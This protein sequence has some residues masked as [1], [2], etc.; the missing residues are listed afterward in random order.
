MCRAQRLEPCAF[1]ALI[2]HYA[3]KLYGFLCRIT[4]KPHDAEDLVQ[5]VFLR[6][7]RTIRD[8]QPTGSFDAWVFQ[9]AVNLARDRIR[10]ARRT[11]TTNSLEMLE[12]RGGTL[13]SRPAEPPDPATPAPD[14]PLR[15]AEDVDRLQ[16]AL[17]KLSEPEREVIMLRHYGQM[18]FAEIA[19][20]MGTPLGT[21]LARAHRGL[22]KLRGWMESS[23]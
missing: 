16:H 8:Y 4:G 1:D 23:S 13:G 14:E 5:E 3:H 10:R 19:K 15:L 18:S 9:I 6:M 12:D 22:A 17:M 20:L 21:A 2:E 11:P 7:V